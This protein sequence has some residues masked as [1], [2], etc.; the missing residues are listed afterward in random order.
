MLCDVKMLEQKSQAG[1]AM[2]DYV[3][4]SRPISSLLSEHGHTPGAC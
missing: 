3:C 1:W 2:I 4:A